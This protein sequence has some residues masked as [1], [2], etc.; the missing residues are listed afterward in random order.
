MSPCRC[1]SATTVSLYFVMSLYFCACSVPHLAPPSPSANTPPH[2]NTHCG[3]LAALLHRLLL[4]GTT[5]VTCPLDWKWK[6]Q[7]W[8]YASIFSGNQ[9][10]PQCLFTKCG[11]SGFCHFSELSTGQLSGH[12]SVGLQLTVGHL[13]FQQAQFHSKQWIAAG[14]S[15]LR[16][17][18][19]RVELPPSV[20]DNGLSLSFT[21]TSCG[22]DCSP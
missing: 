3:A 7:L 9:E 16:E 6:P 11:A 20:A 22:F 1:T 4:T 21:G 5:V 2:S 13:L 12:I 10:S 8:W 18:G 14:I 15:W 19:Q 17:S